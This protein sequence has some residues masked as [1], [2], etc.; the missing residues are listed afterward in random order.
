[1]ITIQSKGRI[2]SFHE[3]VVMGII[4]A[5]PDSF[6]TG[7]L[8]ES[9]DA[10]LEKVSAWCKYGMKVLDIGGQS[11]RPGS[12]RIGMQEETDRVTPVIE[13]IHRAFPDLLL[14]IDTYQAGVARAAI[15]AG[16]HMVNDVSS[17]E[18]DQ[19]MIPTVA[20]MRVPYLLMHM[21]GTPETMQVQPAYTDVTAEVIRWLAD[22]I[23]VC[24]E[25]GIHDI[26]VDPGF[27]FGKTTEHNFTLLRQLS[28]FSVL[29]KPIVAGL[30]RKS[31]ICKTLGILPVDA[32]NGT[33]VLNTIALLH[34]A[35]V[36]RVHDVKE[37]CEAVQLVQALGKHSTG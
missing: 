35:Q 34:G 13:A 6:Y 16:A 8:H 37:A 21:Q 20:D 33:T 26:W 3:P 24:T 30:S 11:T 15:E 31:M 5:T 36:L 29:Q 7:S 14:S 18:M 4:N 12:T 17:G 1:M 10:I 2:Y 9:M 22:K 27:G 19:T 32:L 28:A 25:A 23:V